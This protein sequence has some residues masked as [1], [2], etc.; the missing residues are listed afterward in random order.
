MRR[1]AERLIAPFA[2]DR[3]VLALAGA[4]M[5][6]GIGNSFLIIVIPLYV[7]SDVVGGTAFGLGES[8]I[9]GV[10]LSLF[11]FLNSSV[12]PFTG[13]FSDRLG[14]RK[15]FILI[16]LAGLAMTNLAY[17]FAETYLSLLA[18]RGLQ[19]VSVAFIVPSSVALV[20]ELATRGDRG[21]NMGV[22]N[23][24]RL[25]GFGAG[26]AVAGAVV[27]RGPYALP[28][29]VTVG[30][31]EAAFYIAT[32]AATTSYL[33]VTVLVSD[34]ESTAANAGAD[35]SI[36]IRDRSGPNLLDPIFTLG[37]ASLF[38]ATAI[39]L[40]ATIQPQVNARLEQG[41]TWF[42]LQFAAFIISQVALQ[43]PIGRACDRYGRR[44]FI[45]A[46]MVLLI[47]TTLAQG[48]LLSS[49][50][51][52]VAR[53]FQGVAAAMVFAPSLALA[54]DLAGEGESGS[55]LSI[56]TMAFGYGIALGPLSSGALVGYGFEVPFV[57]GTGLA[58]LGAILVYTQVE[59]TLE[60]TASVPVV[61]DD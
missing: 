48:Y 37:V 8:M 49:A 39:A 53:L 52:F 19:G 45:V 34:P 20:N 32:I 24:F 44:P 30:G 6:D 40:F 13:R 60:T 28:G 25:V 59:E 43:T 47:P 15:P 17:V 33:L 26:P 51:M 16:G 38:M 1:L 21:G 12:Q 54:G 18:I 61:G 57:F 46:G 29:G 41:A 10:I 3:R 55:K 7:T 4:R 22:Y 31:F 58:V 36:P 11:G 56:L 14:R 9:I 2:V 5:A 42:G 35:L 50:L 23:T 27:S